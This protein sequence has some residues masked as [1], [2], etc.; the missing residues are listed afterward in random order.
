MIQK[1][2]LLVATTIVI[3]VG[4][5]GCSNTS[6]ST[7]SATPTASAEPTV[8]VTAAP[9]VSAMTLA[10]ACPEI[11]A[12]TSQYVNQQSQSALSAEGAAL[13]SISN[14]SDQAVQAALAP[15]IASLE[16]QK[17][18]Q[19]LVTAGNAITAACKPFGGAYE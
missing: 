12:V 13:K 15:L 7:P 8:T 19:G 9:T 2:I 4:V 3:S 1:P 6:S 17:G 10:Q 14:K 16:D 11:K 5:V 18:S